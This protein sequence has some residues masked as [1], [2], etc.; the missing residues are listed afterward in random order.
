MLESF[1]HLRVHTEY[2]ISDGL[3]KVHELVERAAALGMPAVAITDRSNL[4]GL[5]KFYDACRSA[6]VKPIIG[7]DLTHF[8]SAT[9]PASRHRCLVL[10]AT[11]TGYR[12]IITL[13]SKSY[14]EMGSERGCVETSWLAAHSDGVV[15]L[16]GGTRGDVGAALLRGDAVAAAQLAERW[17]AHFGDRFYLELQR[18]RRDDEDRYCSAAVTLA[19]ELDLPVVATN[20]VCFL[21]RDDFEA[22]ETR[23]CIQ[24]GR[25]LNDPRR[26][27]RFSEE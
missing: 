10:A 21:G 15:M 5:I 27:R 8:D 11:E 25:T 2:S 22:H 7:A 12:N 1:V 3:T 4:F 19:G 9:D 16:S 23:V 6:G 13:V 18:T 26:V 14:L 20:D 24:E 17:R